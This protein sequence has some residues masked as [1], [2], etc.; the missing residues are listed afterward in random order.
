MCYPKSIALNF[1]SSEFSIFIFS[2]KFK[3]LDSKISNIFKISEDS[4]FRARPI[5]V[6]SP[7][8]KLSEV[9]IINACAVGQGTNLS[10]LNLILIF[11]H[12]LF[13]SV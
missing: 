12:L 10:I 5:T 2:Q 3:N 13:L 1:F 9:S 11:S 6:A 4:D 7:S 8:G